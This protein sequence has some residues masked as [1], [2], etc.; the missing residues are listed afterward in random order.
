MPPTNRSPS[1]QRDVLGQVGPN[2]MLG[3]SPFASAAASS[4]VGPFKSGLYILRNSEDL[5]FKLGDSAVTAEAAVVDNHYVPAGSTVDLTIP[6]GM[7][8]AVIRAGID[9]GV[10]SISQVG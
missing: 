9:D 2:Y 10:G 8:V 5:W 3:S 7:Y 1:V 4:V 6:N